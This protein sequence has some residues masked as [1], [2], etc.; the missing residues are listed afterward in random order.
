[1]YTVHKILNNALREGLSVD[2]CCVQCVLPTQRAGG[3]GGGEGRGGGTLLYGP[4]QTNK[5]VAAAQCCQLRPYFFYTFTRAQR[6][7]EVAFLVSSSVA[8]PVTS[9]WFGSGY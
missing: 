8:D 3:G 1:M 6:T 2:V 5:H 7:Q 9:F 4:G